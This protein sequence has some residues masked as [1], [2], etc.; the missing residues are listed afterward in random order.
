MLPALL[1]VA[2]LFGVLLLVRLGGA[3][4]SLVSRHWIALL[5]A[6][7]AIIALARGAVWPALGLAAAA[8]VAWVAAPLL[9]SSPRAPVDRPTEDPATIEARLVLGIGP[10]ASEGDIRRAYRA[11]MARAHPDKG[12]SHAQAARLTAARD[13]LLRQKR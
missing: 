11:K 3:R 13:L 10:D 12:G 5:L 2:G 8:A 9:F 7:A 4:R 6:G 1:V